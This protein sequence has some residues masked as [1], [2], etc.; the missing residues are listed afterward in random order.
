MSKTQ[1]GPFR[2][3]WLQ[4]WPV[5]WIYT[6]VDTSGT[7]PE[8]DGPTSITSV[9]GAVLLLS[10]LYILRTT[11]LAEKFCSF[12]PRI[13]K[14]LFIIENDEMYAFTIGDSD[15]NHWPS[16]CAVGT[17]Q[18]P[19]GSSVGVLHRAASGGHRCSCVGMVGWRTLARQTP[20]ESIQ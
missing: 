14:I 20:I 19:K 16:S 1:Q 17:A 8:E 10:Y 3:V 11:I 5:V 2:P 15:E 18:N 12:P 7:A 6:R 4:W 9:S 13:L